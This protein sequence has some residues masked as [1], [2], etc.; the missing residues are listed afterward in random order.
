M[1]KYKEVRAI[2]I[3]VLSDR[4]WHT[5]EELQRECEMKG[6]GLDGERGPIYNIVHQ[7]KI[8]EIIDSNGAGEYRMREEKLNQTA[9]NILEENDELENSIK[10]IKMSLEKYKR[11]NWIKCSEEELQK[12][13]MNVGIIKELSDEIQHELDW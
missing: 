12:A 7:L 1:G 13:R 5:T 2:V 6:V 8:K 4:K 10:V 11:F 3:E 9:N